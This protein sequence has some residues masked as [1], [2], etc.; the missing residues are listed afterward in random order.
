[1]EIKY[2]KAQIHNPLEI[3][4]QA[5][6]SAFKDPKTGEESFILRLTSGFYPR[7]H[8]Y[9]N[10]HGEDYG[11]SLHLDQKKPSYAGT[12]AHGGEYDGPTVEKEMERV[13]GWIHAVAQIPIEPEPDFEPH[14][15]P[16]P[17]AEAEFDSP[18]PTNPRKPFGGIFS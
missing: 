9:L 17:Q 18:A 2:P 7:F 4:R 16:E 12:R 6:Y 15:T 5:G 13:N 1:M 11:F 3:L 8:L 14:P 10:D